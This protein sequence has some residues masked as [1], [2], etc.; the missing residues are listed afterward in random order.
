MAA[1][2]GKRHAGQKRDSERRDEDDGDPVRDR[3]REQIGKC[4]DCES[5]RIS[6]RRKAAIILLSILKTKR[7]C[8]SSEPMFSARPVKVW[9]ISAVAEGDI[10]V[11]VLEE[12]VL[13]RLL[14]M[15]FSLL[16][17]VEAP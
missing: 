9:R 2:L 5:W 6:Q 10:Q 17:S 12:I 8:Y 13:P 4:R 14:N 16:P 7:H 1:D 3:H 15:V 11:G